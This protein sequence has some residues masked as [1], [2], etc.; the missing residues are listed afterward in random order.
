LS[1][2]DYEADPRFAVITVSD[3]GKGIPADQLGQIFDKLYQGEGSETY[4]ASG[5]G[6][7]LSICR[8]LVQLH[9]GSIWVESELG[10]GSAFSFTLPKADGPSLN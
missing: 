2:A 7:G 10:K 5:L 3:T 9:G 4:P 1:A 6:L 8:G